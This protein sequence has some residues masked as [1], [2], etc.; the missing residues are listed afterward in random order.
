MH[1]WK[2]NGEKPLEAN[3]NKGAILNCLV[4]KPFISVSLRNP[5]QFNPK[6]LP[7]FL[8]F[9]HQKGLA[10]LAGAAIE[11]KWGGWLSY[12]PCWRSPPP[13]SQN[14]TPAKS[15]FACQRSNPKN[16][17]HISVPVTSCRI[18]PLMVRIG[19]NCKIICDL[20]FL[21]LFKRFFKLG[22]GVGLGLGLGKVLGLGTGLALGL[23]VGWVLCITTRNYSN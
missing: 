11:W 10:F 21:R 14:H 19:Y 20:L 13:P 18:N 4:L 23:M 16:T 6:S 15:S 1:K 5:S 2:V 8:I 17:T 3:F 12:Y 7:C 22:L 9:F